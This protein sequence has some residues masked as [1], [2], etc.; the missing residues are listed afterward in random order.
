M[1]RRKGMV[2]VCSRAANPIDGNQTS[3]WL[4]PAVTLLEDKTD[5]ALNK[6]KGVIKRRMGPSQGLIIYFS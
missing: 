3:T 2:D 1:Q 5:F 6:C 4:S